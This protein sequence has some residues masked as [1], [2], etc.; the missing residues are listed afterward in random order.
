MTASSLLSSYLICIRRVPSSKTSLLSLIGACM[1]T[2][3]DEGELE[4]GVGLLV[5][6]VGF[7]TMGEL[8]TRG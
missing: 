5:V 8:N 4:K 6:I 1:S 7:D 3:V 2:G